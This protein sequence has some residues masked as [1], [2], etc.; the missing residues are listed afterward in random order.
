MGIFQRHVSFFGVI[1]Y[2]SELVPMP[3]RKPL[4]ISGNWNQLDGYDLQFINSFL[5]GGF[6]PFEKLCSSNLII[7]TGFWVKKK[8]IHHHLVIFQGVPE[9]EPKKTTRNEIILVG[10]YNWMALQFIG[11][12]CVAPQKPH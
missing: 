12:F 2:D 10:S 7:S 3:T 9:L 11:F 4:R 6:N 5:V 1:L 8:Q